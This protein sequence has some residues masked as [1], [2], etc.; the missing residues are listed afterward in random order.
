MGLNEAYE[1]AR[2]RK[3][4]ADTYEA[5]FLSLKAA[6]PDLADLVTDG[7]L[8]LV[9]AQAAYDQHVS[10]ERRRKLGMAR[11]LHELAR[12]ADLLERQ[13][14]AVAKFVVSEAELY[15]KQNPDPIDEVVHALEVFAEHASQVL[16]RIIELKAEKENA[17]KS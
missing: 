8:Q 1:E 2:L 13:R 14:D 10:E 3:G 5:R 6:A 9:E 4:Q 11:C 17:E 16:A 15:Q 12:H 7:Q